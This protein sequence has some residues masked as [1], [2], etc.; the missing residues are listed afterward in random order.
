MYAS[1]L[2]TRPPLADSR[3]LHLE[4]VP[5][6]LAIFYEIDDSWMWWHES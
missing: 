4:L 3:A 2:K 6:T 5:S 1:F